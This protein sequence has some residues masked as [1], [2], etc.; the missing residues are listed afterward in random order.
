MTVRLNVAVFGPAIL[1]ENPATM[2]Y[3]AENGVECR[4]SIGMNDVTNAGYAAMRVA[5][6]APFEDYGINVICHIEAAMLPDNVEKSTTVSQYEA[7]YGACM[8]VYEAEGDYLRGYGYEVGYDNG[9]QWLRGRT[10]RYITFQFNNQGYALPALSPVWSD[11]DITWRSQY[12]DEL[13]WELSEMSIIWSYVVPGA[14]WMAAN[15]PNKDQ[16]VNTTFS[17]AWPGEDA[18]NSAGNWFAW[19]DWIDHGPDGTEYPNDPWLSVAEQ[20]R[21]AATYMSLLKPSGGKLASVEAYACDDRPAGWW[22]MIEQIQWMQSLNLDGLG[23]KGAFP[24]MSQ[25]GVTPYY[26]GASSCAYYNQLTST[27]IPAPTSDTFTNTGNEII[28]LKSYSDST[29]HTITVS[30]THAHKNYTVTIAPDHP[31]FLGPYSTDYFGTLPT[32]TYDNTNLYVSI[33]K[34]TPA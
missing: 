23:T 34:D 11:H 25:Q 5:A 27:F 22:S 33:I 6:W 29:T 16:G 14:Q 13:V 30:G 26:T 1:T 12:F 28:M 21:R 15:L 24:P 32:I 8:D 31:T 10:D 17:P 19:S 20:H 3:M 2:K 7:A 4:D 9:A 18:T